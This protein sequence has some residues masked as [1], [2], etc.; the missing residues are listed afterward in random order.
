MNISDLKSFQ[1]LMKTTGEYYERKTP[2]TGMAAEM[3]FRGLKK[4]S[5]EQV[6]YAVYQHIETPDSGRFFPKVADLV[7]ILEGGRIT[8]DQVIGMARLK[9]TPLGIYAWLHIGS[10]S[11]DNSDTFYLKQRAEEVIQELPKIKR[12][13][14]SG[15][16]DP[17]MLAIME[18][19]GVSPYAPLFDEG[20]PPAS[21]DARNAIK[22]TWRKF[23][24]TDKYRLAKGE[25]DSSEY[26]ERISVPLIENL[27]VTEE[28]IEDAKKT[29]KALQLSCDGYTEQ[30]HEKIARS[31][32]G[33]VNG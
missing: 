18:K 12:M 8:P 13:F 21:L 9:Q 22:Q 19:Y 4:Y 24:G 5:Y 6:E 33:K 25:I 30:G 7:Q 26:A 11:L 1:G 14:F 3:Y 27:S 10:W 29:V 15:N 32:T 31:N 20:M 16:Y 28:Q 2:V 17:H 23:S